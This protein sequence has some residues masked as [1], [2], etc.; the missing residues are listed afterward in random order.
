MVKIIVERSVIMG[1]FTERH[2]WTF[3]RSYAFS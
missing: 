1:D 3:G 2:E